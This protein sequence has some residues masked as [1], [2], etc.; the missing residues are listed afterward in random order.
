VLVFFV[1]P[2]AFDFE[3]DRDFVALAFFGLAAADVAVVEAAVDGAAVDVVA[4]LFVAVVAFLAGFVPADFERARF[5]V[6]AADV[7][8]LVAFFVFVDFFL[9]G[10]ASPTANLNEPLA[11]LPLVCLNDLALTPFLRANLRC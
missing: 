11:P 8:E 9:A 6:P 10:L 2:V 4:E 1:A 7:V 3:L 5:F